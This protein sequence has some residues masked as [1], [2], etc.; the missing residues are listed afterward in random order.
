MTAVEKPTTIPANTPHPVVRFQSNDT[1]SGDEGDDS[2]YGGLQ[3]DQ[4]S[5]GAGNDLVYGS[6]GLSRLLGVALDGMPAQGIVG[7]T[8]LE[9]IMAVIGLVIFGIA[10]LAAVWGIFGFEWAVIAGFA[11]AAG[12]REAAR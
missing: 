9:L 6:F 5:G 10:S 1:I 3:S 11:H 12:L 2:I 8:V 4:I 7:A